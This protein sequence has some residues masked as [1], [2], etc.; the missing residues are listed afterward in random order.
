MTKNSAA[1]N[2]NYIY[3]DFLHL[4]LLDLITLVN[5]YHVDNNLKAILVYVNIGSI[6]NK[7]PKQ[8]LDFL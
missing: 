4:K 1:I 3:L 7:R 6:V 2:N 8:E 5:D